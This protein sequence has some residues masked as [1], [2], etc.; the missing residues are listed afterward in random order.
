[1]SVGLLY[2]GNDLDC[3][4]LRTRL[5]QMTDGELARFGRTAQYMC[6]R[7]PNFGKPPRQVFVIQLEEARIEWNRRKAER[8][9]KTKDQDGATNP[10]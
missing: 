3:D 1:M 6:S 8:K 2:S 7:R 10:R 9:A 4:A 5:R